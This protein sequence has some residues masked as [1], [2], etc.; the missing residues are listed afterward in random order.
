[1]LD[2]LLT[3]KKEL[4]SGDKT[5]NEIE[6]FAKSLLKLKKDIEAMGIKPS[7][8]KLYGRPFKEQ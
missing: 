2:T 1:M 7:K 8:E 5:Q 4:T 3:A 6:M